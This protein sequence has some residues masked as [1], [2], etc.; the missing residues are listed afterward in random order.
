MRHSK[1]KVKKKKTQTH[2]LIH[3]KKK[4]KYIYIYNFSSCRIAKK[5]I[6]HEGLISK[7]NFDNS[8]SFN[9]HSSIHG[10]FLDIGTKYFNHVLPRFYVKRNEIGFD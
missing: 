3:S 10:N 2:T 8:S 6:Y 1:K 5:Y 9:H 4:V 7:L